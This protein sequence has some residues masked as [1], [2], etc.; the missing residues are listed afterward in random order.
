[1]VG[2]T[3]QVVS[4]DPAGSYDK[5]SFA[6]EMQVYQFLYSFV[7]G[8]TTP[9][10]D[11]TQRTQEIGQLQTLLATKYLPTVP[12]LQGAQWAFTRNDVSGI[13]FLANEILPLSMITKS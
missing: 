2:T 9:Q 5:G 3:D 12:L 4:L 7:P 1:M 13:N 6:V 8:N 11:P 10:T